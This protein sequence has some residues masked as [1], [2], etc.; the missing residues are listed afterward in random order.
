[1]EHDLSAFE[2][3]TDNTTLVLG[4]WVLGKVKGETLLFRLGIWSAKM[5]EWGAFKDGRDNARD[6]SS[7]FSF[8]PDALVRDGF[9]KARDRLMHRMAEDVVYYCPKAGMMITL[10][11][12]MDPTRVRF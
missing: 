7:L 10:S 2:P 1:M 3:I 11:P 9:L 5:R 12:G 6:G 8:M 4:D